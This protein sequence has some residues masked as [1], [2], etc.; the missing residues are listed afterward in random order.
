MSQDVYFRLSIIFSTYEKSLGLKDR[1]GHPVKSTKL[2]CRTYS[3]H[4]RKL[5]KNENEHFA[6]QSKNV[7]KKIKFPD[8][9]RVQ[10]LFSVNEI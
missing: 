8:E 9:S 7:V 3:S 10:I 2:V 4:C 1:D 5:P 6:I